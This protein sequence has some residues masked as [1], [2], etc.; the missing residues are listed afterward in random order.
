MSRNVRFFPSVENPFP[1][2]ITI[3]FPSDAIDFVSYAHALFLKNELAVAL[4]EETMAKNLKISVSIVP[5]STLFSFGFFSHNAIFIRNSLTLFEK[6]MV[7]LFELC[8]ICNSA[9]DCTYNPKE[10]SDAK[11]FATTVEHAEFLSLNRAAQIYQLGF[12]QGVWP[13]FAVESEQ[14]RAFGVLLKM[15]CDTYLAWAQTPMPEFNG[16]T[17]ASYYEQLFESATAA[18]TLRA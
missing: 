3:A 15:N 10:F 5:D 11:T 1:L 13:D 12:E 17:H 16:A 4:I 6:S 7:F 2:F 18:S 9:L 8:N 14:T